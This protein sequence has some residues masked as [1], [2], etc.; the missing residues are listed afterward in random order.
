M[1]S[2]SESVSAEHSENLPSFAEVMAS[3]KYQAA[4]GQECCACKA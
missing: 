2:A 4:N 3:V 1:L